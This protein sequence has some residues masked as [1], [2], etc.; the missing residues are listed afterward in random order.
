M[1]IVNVEIKAGL[2]EPDKVR[3]VLK[4]GGARFVGTDHQTDTYFNV[5]NGRLKLREG[6]IENALIYYKRENK[7]GPKKSDVKLYK[8]KPDSGLKSLLE[9]SLGILAVVDKIREIYFIG[10]VKFHIDTVEQLGSFV[11]IEAI[12]ENGD[13]GEAKLL[14]QCENYLYLFGISDKDLI[15]VSYSDLI[16]NKN[17]K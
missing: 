10:N 13:I 15:S 9:E 12:D 4:E 7:P 14:K 8:S 5:V 1:S 16:L 11:E 17:N 2:A 3:S 6:E